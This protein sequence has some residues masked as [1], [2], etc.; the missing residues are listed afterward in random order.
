MAADELPII[1]DTNILFSAL[2][3]EKSRITHV[4][5]FSHLQFFVGE[6]ALVELFEH[7][8]RIARI[9]RLEP[10]LLLEALHK[11]LRK[12]SFYKEDFIGEEHWRTAR[13]LCADVD[14]DDERFIALTLALDGLLWTG[15]KRLRRGLEAKGFDR[16]FSPDQE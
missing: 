12:V 14:P 5:L 10:D 11:I 13:E 16:F 4:I 7:K 9:S 8:E 6:W 1:L 2:L 15:D 3:A